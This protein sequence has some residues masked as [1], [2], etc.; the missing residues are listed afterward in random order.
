MTGSPCLS[1]AAGAAPA[2]PECC[3]EQVVTCFDDAS[4]MVQ[5]GVCCRNLWKTVSALEKNA[6]VRSKSPCPCSKKL[7]DRVARGGGKR[8]CSNMKEEH[9]ANFCHNREGH[10]DKTYMRNGSRNKPKVAK[11]EDDDDSLATESTADAAGPS[12]PPRA[13]RA[14]ANGA[15]STA[16]VPHVNCSG[17]FQGHSMPW[18]SYHADVA[19]FAANTFAGMLPAA[20]EAPSWH[21]SPALGIAGFATSEQFAEDDYGQDTPLD[22]PAYVQWSSD[23]PPPGLGGM[24]GKSS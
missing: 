24:L 8:E 1:Q 15:V 17:W 18:N 13:S 9:R 5:F 19:F 23:L 21:R 14:R 6:P 11:K 22:E 2:F 7:C 16:D 4:T 3:S 12:R 20:M 10:E